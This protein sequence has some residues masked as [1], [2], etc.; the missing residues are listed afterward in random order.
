MDAKG[1]SPYDV[2]LNMGKVSVMFSTPKPMNND[3]IHYVNQ[4]FTATA[5]RVEEVGFDGVENLLA[6]FYR[7]RP[8]NE[9]INGEGTLKI[10]IVY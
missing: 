1:L 7:H 10:V 4:R 5:T 9:M 2:A 8:T 6:Q 3:E